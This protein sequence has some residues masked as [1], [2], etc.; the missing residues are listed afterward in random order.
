[1][2]ALGF[3]LASVGGEWLFPLFPRRVIIS[4]EERW[5]LGGV[6]I[7]ISVLASLLGIAKALRIE[8]NQVLS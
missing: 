7:A 5:M 4:S 2:G 6:V 8:P 3:V 1:L